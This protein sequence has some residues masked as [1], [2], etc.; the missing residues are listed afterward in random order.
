MYIISMHTRLVLLFIR[1]GLEYALLRFIH[2][3]TVVWMPLYAYCMHITRLVC[4]IMIC[5]LSI[6]LAS[7][8]VLEYMHHE[9]LCPI[10][11]KTKM[12]E[13]W[14]C[15]LAEL[16]RE[17]LFPK[18]TIDAPP[19]GTPARPRT[20]THPWSSVMYVCIFWRGTARWVR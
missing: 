5:I 15:R 20:A 9:S 13:R 8:V 18:G 1:A 10:P 16:W 4:Y 19:T 17:S 3:H 7:L 12:V 14:Q 11:L 2:M 6:I